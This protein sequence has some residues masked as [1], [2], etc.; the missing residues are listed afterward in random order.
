M[1]R[2]EIFED[3]KGYWWCKKITP[4]R[5]LWWCWESVENALSAPDNTVYG[6]EALRNCVDKWNAEEE[7]KAHRPKKLRAVYPPPPTKEEA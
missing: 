6:K 3:E 7:R 1:K 5:F 4:H 2:Y